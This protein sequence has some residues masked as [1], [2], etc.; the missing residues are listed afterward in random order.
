MVAAAR[1]AS[2]IEEWVLP[3]QESNPS[4]MATH[5]KMGRISTP[6]EPGS[7]LCTTSRIGGR[8]A[9]ST[10]REF[11]PAANHAPPRIFIHNVDI[12]P[13]LRSVASLRRGWR[14]SPRPGRRPHPHA[15][16]ARPTRP[17]SAARPVS[18][19]RACS[20]R[21]R[22]ILPQLRRGPR[23]RQ[24]AAI[25]QRPRL[26]R[27]TRPR[28]RRHRLRIGPVSGWKSLPATLTL[29]TGIDSSA[30]GRCAVP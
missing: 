5:R 23:R 7:Q 29:L 30:Y 28:W 10:A 9:G 20:N 4:R 14:R 13:R 2:P 24:S 19:P 15:P 26:P 17:A 1:P 16:A 25:P 6:S 18:S 8:V 22:R 27:Q 3:L 12:A 11:A 21:H